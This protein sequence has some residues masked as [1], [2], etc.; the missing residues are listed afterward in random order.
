MVPSTPRAPPE[1]A[2]LRRLPRSDARVVFVD[3][4][5]LLGPHL[6]S[7]GRLRT[8]RPHRHPRRHPRRGCRRL[9]K[10]PSRKGKRVPDDA[11]LAGRVLPLERR[12]KGAGAARSEASAFQAPS[13]RP[14]STR[15]DDAHTSGT[16]GNPKKGVPLSRTAT[17]APTRRTG[18]ATT[19]P[20]FP[21]GRRR[22]LAAD[23]PHLR[24]R[25]DGPRQPPRLHHV[26]E[27][28]GHGARASRAEA[29]R[30]HERPGLL[31]EARDAGDG[32][33]DPRGQRRSSRASRAEGCASA[34]RARGLKRRS[35]SSSTSMGC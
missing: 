12:A 7:V 19:S 20:L 10:K 28:P 3:T 15:R 9:A 29:E 5:A 22:A 11:A 30:L 1:Q 34:C 14:T 25:R 21:G 23:E 18:S 31:G 33:A 26:H 16:S 35:R 17:S 4:P 13:R 6:Q 32:G 8:R 2:A 24:L 27:R